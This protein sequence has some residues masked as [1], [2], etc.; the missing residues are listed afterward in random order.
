MNYFKSKFFVDPVLNEIDFSNE[1][2]WMVQL[3]NTPEFKRL[4]RIHQL[5]VTYIIFPTATHN[6]LSHSLGAFEIVRRFIK[7]LHLDKLELR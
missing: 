1:N 5:G 3:I 7:H 2:N 4:N 6:R